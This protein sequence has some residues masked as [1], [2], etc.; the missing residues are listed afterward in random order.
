MRFLIFFLSFLSFYFYYSAY[1]PSPPPHTHNISHIPVQPTT[2][3]LSIAA[4]FAISKLTI[5]S[6][7]QYVTGILLYLKVNC[8]HLL[9]NYF[10]RHIMH[11]CM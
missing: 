9:G 5:Y 2:I 1:R 10:T 4:I 8:Y 3:G 11:A 7:M 6:K